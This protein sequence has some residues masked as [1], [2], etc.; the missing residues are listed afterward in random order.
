MRASARGATTKI[1]MPID[2]SETSPGRLSTRSAAAA[3]SGDIQF[4]AS[5]CVAAID[6]APKGDGHPVLTLP[7]SRQRSSMPMRNI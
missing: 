4:N 2:R 7:A 6:A 5:L 3:R 1:A